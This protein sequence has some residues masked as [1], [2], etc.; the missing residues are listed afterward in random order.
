MTA[1]SEKTTIY[2]KDYLPPDY[3]VH[4]V[5]LHISIESDATI[6]T[7]ELDIERSETA[8]PNTALRLHGADLELLEL[9][10]NGQ[11]VPAECY[12]LVG[13]ELVIENVPPSPFTLK[14]CVRI[15]PESNTAL[16]GLYCS[17]GMYCTQCEAEGFRKITYYPDR[18]DVMARFTTTLDAEKKRFPVLLANGN[19]VAS[20]ESAIGRH[21]ELRHFV[22]WEDPFPKPAYLFAMVAGNLEC[23]LDEFITSSGRKIDLRIY[24]ESRDVGKVE[25][26]MASLKRS[27]RWDEEV[28]GREYDL[29][30]FMIVAVSHFNMGAMENKGLNIFNTSCVLAHHLTTTDAGFQRVESVVAHEYFHNWSGNRV[31][32]RDWFQLSLKEGF[33]VF[34]DQQF[35]AD[36]LS[37]SVQRI[38]D[39]DALRSWQFAEDSGPLAH[40]V[41]PESFVEINNFYTATVYEKGAE[42]VRMLHTVLGPDNFRAGTDLYFSRHDGQA[43]TVEDFIRALSDA[44]DIDLGEFL[45][46]YRQPGTPLLRA[47]GSYNA[48]LCTYTLRLEQALPTIPGYPDPLLLPVPVRFSLIGPDGNDL[49]VL[50]GQ[51]MSSSHVLILRNHYQEYEFLNVNSAPVPSLLRD[52]S[53]PVMLEHSLNQEERL[54]LLRHDNNGFNR[55]RVTQDLLA[56]EILRLAA[57]EAA[58]LPDKGLLDAIEGLLPELAEHDAALAAKLLQFPTVHQLMEN[59]AHPDPEALHHA[60]L[61]LRSAVTSRLESWFLS[62]CVDVPERDA[63]YRYDACS[64]ARRSLVNT[65]LG[66][67]VGY[68]ADHAS[69]AVRRFESATNMTNQASALIA[70]VHAGC[71]EGSDCLAAFLQQWRHEP[72]VMDQ[73]FA[74][75]ASAPLSSTAGRIRELL[76]HPDFDRTSPNR[77]R[78]VLG[79]FA[80]ANPVAF[81][82]ADGSGYQIL[83]AEIALLDSINPQIAARLLGA[84]AVWPR[85][86]EKRQQAVLDELAKLAHPGI[87]PDLAENLSRLTRMQM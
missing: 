31:T 67:L 81:H 29:D 74:I 16:E 27:M 1:E 46:W 41:R 24:V 49:H 48:D 84:L 79:Q 78:S 51:N 37:H 3:H 17:D 56:A 25:H 33:T 85:L 66:F 87:S 80:N 18:P 35:S 70:L 53:A 62:L 23:C 14:S 82:Q 45:Q 68:S 59:A 9:S 4:H 57:G 83:C 50:H 19:Q 55:W 60:R 42:I 12:K 44:S 61:A 63:V 20:G 7:A 28:Y 26:A 71:V 43:V 39:V 52:F 38:E 5:R 36:M 77:V 65:A 21:G 47:E 6:V 34:R 15:H 22:T 32:C 73:W 75:Q 30:I 76:A 8:S 10:F 40:P 69:L 86:D 64:I 72:L 58:L 11:V 54:F 2:L 13:E